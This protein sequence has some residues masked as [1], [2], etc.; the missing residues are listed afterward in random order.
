MNEKIDTT[1]SIVLGAIGGL[2]IEWEA[3]LASAVNAAVAGFIGALFGLFAKWV[4]KK[5][6]KK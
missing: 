3:I 5:Y 4:W 1:M 2:A 6:I